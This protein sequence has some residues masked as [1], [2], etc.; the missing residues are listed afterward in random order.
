MYIGPRGKAELEQVRPMV[1]S[2][3]GTYKRYGSSGKMMGREMTIVCLILI[4][5]H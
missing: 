1:P 2:I 3:M 5:L 4:A